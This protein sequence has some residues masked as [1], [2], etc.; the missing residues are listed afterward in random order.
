MPSSHYSGLWKNIP[1]CLAQIQMGLGA[2]A[3]RGNFRVAGLR[4][5]FLNQLI[6][7]VSVGVVAFPSAFLIFW[8]IRKTKGIRVSAEEELRGLDLGEH[9]MEAYPGFQFFLNQ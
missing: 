9:G 7:V 4:I 1:R 2:Y 3:G 8:M 6:G 5:T